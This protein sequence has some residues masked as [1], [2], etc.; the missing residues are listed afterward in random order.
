MKKFLLASAAVF[1][2]ASFGAVAHAEDSDY[3]QDV[4]VKVITPTEAA[5]VAAIRA[6]ESGVNVKSTAA[7]ATGVASGKFVGVDDLDVNQDI[8]VQSNGGYTK[9][10]TLLTADYVKGGVEGSGTADGQLGGVNG[11]IEIAFDS[12]TTISSA[13]YGGQGSAS[14]E[15]Y[16]DN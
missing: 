16:G 2:F 7:G 10:S 1:A 15:V 8:N 6:I 4:T 12:K 5:T 14:L 13:A 11:G 3:E 9:A